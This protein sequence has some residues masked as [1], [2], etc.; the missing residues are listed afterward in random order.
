[1]NR[2]MFRQ[3]AMWLIVIDVPLVYFG[4]VVFDSVL[5]SVAALIVMGV[6][7]VVAVV[8]Y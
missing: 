6:A 2:A 5:A 3:V 7:A 4:S 1:M 8:V